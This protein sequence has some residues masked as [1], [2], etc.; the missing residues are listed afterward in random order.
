MFLKKLEVQGFK[1]FPEKIKL[2]FKK[3]ITGVVGPNGSGKSNISDA[4]R[5]VLGE[6]SA[7]SLRGD[8]MEDIIFAGTKNRKPLGFAEVSMTLDNTDKKL[9]LD[10]S[11]ITIT[12]KVY[13]SGESGYYING[14]ACRLKDIHELFMDTGIGKEGYSIIGQGKIDAILSNKS[15]DRRALFE[16]AVGIVKFKNRRTQAEN[17]LEEVRQNLTR[18]NDIIAELE[19][20][21][22]PLEVQEKKAKEYL[23][24]AEELKLIRVNLFKYEYKNSEKE[25][26]K[27]NNYIKILIESIDRL[28]EDKNKS[29]F[30]QEQFKKKLIE[31]DN[32]LEKLNEEVSKARINIEQE[33]S[34]IKLDLKNIEF[35]KNEIY[36]LEKEYLY[37]EENIK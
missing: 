25:I 2:N 31:N 3:G 24:L 8:K 22:K 34:N 17:K 14:T 11:E 9:N 13:R 29:E 19:R 18:T 33:E 10:F 6:Q 7:K 16:E 37:F 12:R 23:V 30:E 26:E 5:W 1:S 20:Q 4:I 15:E 32:A 27:I 35:I 36:R 21:I 28:E